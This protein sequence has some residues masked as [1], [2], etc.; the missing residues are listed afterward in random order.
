MKVR[1]QHNIFHFEFQIVLGTNEYMH[2][3]KMSTVSFTVLYV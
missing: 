1:K 3:Y 2:A